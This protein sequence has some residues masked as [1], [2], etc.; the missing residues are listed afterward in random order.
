MMQR[1]LAHLLLCALVACACTPRTRGDGGAV[2][3]M[4]ERGGMHAAVL[5]AP[6]T[7]RVGAIEFAWIGARGE[8]VAVTATHAS[9][10]VLYAACVPSSLTGEVHALLEFSK[11]GVWNIEVDPDATGGW[12]AARFDIE[13]GDALPQWTASWMYLFA[14][15]P[16]AGIGLF[17]AMRRIPRSRVR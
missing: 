1:T 15:I 3:W 8:V 2:V 17:A 12:E 7:P 11:S 9:G 4:G 6:A 14:W 5:V 16:I 10:A 13:V